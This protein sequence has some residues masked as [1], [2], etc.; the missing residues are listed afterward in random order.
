MN[1]GPMTILRER[2]R[3]VS[4]GFAGGLLLGLVLG[5]AFH[6]VISFIVRFGF[7]A[8][9]LVPLALVFIFWYRLSNRDRD[10]ERERLRDLAA[11][12]DDEFGR[13]DPIETR[14][15]VVEYRQVRREE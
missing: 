12:R 9:L 4:Y 14:G 5:W 15:E 2:F 6:G 1:L 10:R 13:V 3:F 11:R 8:L 7:V